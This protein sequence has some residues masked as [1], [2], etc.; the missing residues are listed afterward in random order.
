MTGL[1]STPWPE[2]LPLTQQAA[3]V[4]DVTGELVGWVLA[5]TPDDAP[6]VVREG[7]TVRRLAVLHGQCPSCGARL[8][9][10]TRRE[11]RHATAG[12]R[13]PAGVPRIS[14]LASCPGNDAVLDAALVRWHAAGGGGR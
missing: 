2:H 14:H 8:I 13:A 4:D 7:V 12:G 1:T 10:G 11:R 5:D 9:W 3:V 6:P